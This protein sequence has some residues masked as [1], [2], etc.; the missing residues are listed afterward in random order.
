MAQQSVKDKQARTKKYVDEKRHA[1]T[2][3]IQV[4]DEVLVKQNKTNKFTPKFNTEPL[5]VTRV[6]GTR[7]LATTQND[8][9]TYHPQCIHFKKFLH[10]PEYDREDEMTDG[11]PDDQP[12]V[13]NGL[14][15]IDLDKHLR[16]N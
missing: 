5:I 16:T 1:K 4:G 11:E 7:I 15:M 6:A 13:P 10:P 3:N 8:S 2:T 12:Q 9:S 14:P